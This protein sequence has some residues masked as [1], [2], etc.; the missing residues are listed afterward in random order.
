[1]EAAAQEGYQL[2]G[3]WQRLNDALPSSEVQLS[4]LEW[5][6]WAMLTE[7]LAIG[8]VARRLCV[9]DLETIGAIKR[10]RALNLIDESD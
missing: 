9:P 1:M 6:A 4:G 8:D 5:M 7:P 3:R 10:L 2:D